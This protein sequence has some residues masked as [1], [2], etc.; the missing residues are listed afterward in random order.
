MGDLADGVL[1]VLYV[2]DDLDR[3]EDAVVDDGLMTRMLDPASSRTIAA[4]AISTHM[5]IIS[6]S[7]WPGTCSIVTGGS[8]R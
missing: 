3:V 6:S 5:M 7:I 8:R 1:V 2:D 4:I